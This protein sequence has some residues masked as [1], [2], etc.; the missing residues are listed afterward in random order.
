MENA[1]I[2]FSIFHRDGT[3]ESGSHAC[4]CGWLCPIHP[5]DP[6]GPGLR[7]LHKV[8]PRNVY[9]CPETKDILNTAS[10]VKCQG[11]NGISVVP[12]GLWGQGRL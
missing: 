4:V 11:R 12:A 10:E 5:A 2:S 9:K 1:A 3:F 8:A 6:Q 7:L